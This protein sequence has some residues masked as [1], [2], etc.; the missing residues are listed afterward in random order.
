VCYL[1]AMN[2][3][4]GRVGVW[5]LS[6]SLGLGA[7]APAFAKAKAK[8]KSKSPPPSAQNIRAIAD[9]AKPYKWGMSVD[10][11]VKVINDEVHAKYVE[12]LSK[13]T[14]VY[15]QD[16]LRKE[17]KEELAKAK[18]SLVLF[19]GKK[20]GWDT[21]LIDHEF[22]QRNDES[23]LVRWEPLQRRFLFFIHNKLYKQFVAFNAEKF[24][25]KTFDDFAKMME[26]R[27]GRSEMKLATMKT[28]DEVVVDHLEWAPQGA[29]TLWAIDQTSFYG[30]FCLKL[31]DTPMVALVEKAHSDKAM[32]GPRGNALIDA[33]TKP[34][35][36]NTDPNA[37]IVDDIL[38][39]K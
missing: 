19:D 36:N 9:L 34:E 35:T 3:T 1:F 11:V 5:I 12:L 18:E 24:K 7:A 33:V 32:K 23:M 26:D 13:E 39:K 6:V 17:E 31:I 27:Y 21:S 10:E 38:K 8:A 16:L 30:N 29:F 20:S 2:R 15:K 25:G 14:D 22:L 4:L 28:K 37:N